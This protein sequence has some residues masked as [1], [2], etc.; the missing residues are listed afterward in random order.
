MVSNQYLKFIPAVMRRR[1]SKEFDYC[2]LYAVGITIIFGVLIILVYILD[3][4]HAGNKSLLLEARGK[5]SR[6]QKDPDIK[7]VTSAFVK[8]FKAVIEDKSIHDTLHEL[9]DLAESDPSELILKLQE[10]DPLGISSGPEGFHCP[11]SSGNSNSR[12]D[13]PSLVNEESSIH[14]KE[15]VE[16]SFIFYQHLRK[17]GGTGFCDLANSNLPR[18]SIPSYY[19]MPDQRGSLSTPPWSEPKYLIDKMTEKNF[20]IAANEWD[21]FYDTQADIKNVVLGTTIRHPID[22]WYSQYRFEH[23]EHR[24]GSSSDAKRNSIKNWYNG[25]KGW[26]M[27]TNYY[28]K[29]FIG[30]LKSV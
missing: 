28:V 17:A 3:P 2:K 5:T 23:L 1:K 12:I 9:F 30:M 11:S 29:T 8:D 25:M 7:D 21:V 18:S 16:G 20:K 26:T 27:G 4:H 22:R 19:C 10:E 6:G 24:D 15:G 14:F 13:F